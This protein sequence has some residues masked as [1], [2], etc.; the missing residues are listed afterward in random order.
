MAADGLGRAR[1]SSHTMRYT[2]S[3]ISSTNGCIM[4][5]QILSHYRT[6]FYLATLRFLFDFISIIS[7]FFHSATSL[8]NPETSLSGADLELYSRP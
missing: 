5:W 8:S 6:L 4:E 7:A 2:E 1:C 3:G